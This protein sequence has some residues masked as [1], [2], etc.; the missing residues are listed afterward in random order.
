[1]QSASHLGLHGA[2][3]LRADH[4]RRAANGQHANFGIARCYL[5]IGMHLMRHSYIYLPD[6]VRG[7]ATFAARKAYYQTIWSYVLDKWK[8]Y[9]AHEVAFASENLLGQWR[10]VVQS[11]YNIKLKIK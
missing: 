9:D 3:D 2:E 11:V 7:S 4:K 8:R 1:M 6:N 10:D 5:R